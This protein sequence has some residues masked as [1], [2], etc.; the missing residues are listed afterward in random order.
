MTVL[1]WTLG[2]V[3]LQRLIEL[4]HARR[5]TARLRWRGAVEA[6]AGGYPL[7]VLLHAGWLVSLAL[8]VPA[9]T[10][11]NWL[12]IGLYALLQLGRIWVIVSLGGYWTTRI[13]TLPDAPLVQTGPF[14]YLRHPNYLLV[15]AEIAV[16]PLAFGAVAVATAFSALNLM[17]IARRIRIEE[18]VLAPRRGA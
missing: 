8:F 9:E 2:L 17:L 1:Y 12:L 13:I 16:L 18:R 15:A 11:P 10:S 3:A 4:A 6:D 5:N 7:Y 14:R